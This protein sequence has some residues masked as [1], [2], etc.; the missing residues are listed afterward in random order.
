MDR[1]RIAEDS[2]KTLELYMPGGDD[3]LPRVCSECGGPWLC[4]SRSAEP[5]PAAPG[6]W[7]WRLECVRGHQA[8][9]VDLGGV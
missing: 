4:Q 3:L 8:E 9:V 2:A 6:R 7:R 1:V 5:L